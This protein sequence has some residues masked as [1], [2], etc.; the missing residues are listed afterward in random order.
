MQSSKNKYNM[1]NIALL[2][3]LMAGL[4]G[5]NHE[6]ET[7]NS[8]AKQLCTFD[9][10]QI[11]L[12]TANSALI[13]GKIIFEG[14]PAYTERGFCYTIAQNPTIGDTKITVAGSGIG[15]Y[16]SEI[17]NLQQGT[18][19]YI[20]AYA[21][22]EAGIAYSAENSFT[23]ESIDLENGLTAYYSFDNEDCTNTQGNGQYNA[24]S[25]EGFPPEFSTDIPDINGK[26]V[27]FDGDGAFYIADNPFFELIKTGQDFTVSLWFK[28]MNTNCAFWNYGKGENFRGDI[29]SFIIGIHDGLLF[30][31]YYSSYSGA[32]YFRFDDSE[33]MNLT[34]NV[35]HFLTFTGRFVGEKYS[36]FYDYYYQCYVD[37]I[38]VGD[39]KLHSYGRPFHTNKIFLLGKGFTGKMD[40]FRVYNRELTQSEITEIYNA[41]Q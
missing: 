6:P 14:K 41:K 40:N 3:L 28:T 29:G 13:T 8:P 16:A 39:K 30:Y 38:K 15:S 24:I 37:G 20:R 26:S 7:D 27:S 35:W 18:V 11:S 34:D 17:Q 25:I 10:N 31:Q 2:L 32:Y 4:Y 9:E 19:Y 23:T 1:K 12:V 22:N 33:E 36:G 21:I 5:C